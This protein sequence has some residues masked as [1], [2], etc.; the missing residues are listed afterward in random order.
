MEISLHNLKT[1]DLKK[2]K[3]LFAAMWKDDAYENYSVIISC[4][5]DAIDKVILEREETE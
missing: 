4:W 2:M 3:N 1:S 5:I